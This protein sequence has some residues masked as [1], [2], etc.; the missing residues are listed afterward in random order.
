MNSKLKISLVLVASAGTIAFC[1]Y[2]FYKAYKTVKEEMEIEREV[3]AEEKKHEEVKENKEQHDAIVKFQEI[4]E[5]H[6]AK[7][8]QLYKDTYETEEEEEYVDE[9]DMEEEEVEKLRH[10]PN[11]TEAMNQFV[12]MNIS[13]ISSPHAGRVIDELFKVELNLHPCEY[14]TSNLVQN[15]IEFFGEGSRWV[16]ELS[17]AD[18]LLHYAHM[19]NYDVNMDVEHSILMFLENLGIYD[20][21][22]SSNKFDSSRLIVDAFVDHTY[23]NDGNFGM[24]GLDE[25]EM[26]HIIVT[27][28]RTDG[29]KLVTFQAEYNTY[30]EGV[31]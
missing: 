12:M 5:Q 28:M 2:H 26:D 29:D 17:V 15:R 3:E 16:T 8:E 6:E 21:T 27:R 30:I 10:D 19:L 7:V 18:L 13:D 14:V 20:S 23:C 24:F 4:K 25:A 11:S 1:G 31:I 9:D 22:V